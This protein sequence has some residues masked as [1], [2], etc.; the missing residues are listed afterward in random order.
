[1]PPPW[2]RPR[3]RSR[4]APTLPSRYIRADRSRRRSMSSLRS[5]RR[6]RS[7]VPAVLVVCAAAALQTACAEPAV[8]IPA[9]AVDN[10]KTQGGLETAVLAGGCF[11]GMQGVFEHVKGVRQVIS[12]FSGGKKDTAH[13]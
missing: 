4:V 11:W 9:A 10:P 6:A 13:Y 1:M 3:P 8:S 12:G 5:Q 7:F 2:C